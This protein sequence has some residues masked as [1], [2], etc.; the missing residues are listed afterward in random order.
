MY[1]VSAICSYIYTQGGLRFESGE[2]SVT[3]NIDGADRSLRVVRNGKGSSRLDRGEITLSDLESFVREGECIPVEID[4]EGVRVTLSLDPRSAMGREGRAAVLDLENATS[5][6]SPLERAAV[7]RSQM[8]SLPYGIKNSGEILERVSW[9]I[10]QGEIDGLSPE[11]LRNLA[12]VLDKEMTERL[13]ESQMRIITELSFGVADRTCDPY[14]LACMNPAARAV[15]EEQGFVTRSGEMPLLDVEGMDKDSLADL[16]ELGCVLDKEYGAVVGGVPLETWLSRRDALFTASGVPWS[17]RGAAVRNSSGDLI[18]YATQ[19][20]PG[21]TVTIQ[22][23]WVVDTG[24]EDL[25]ELLTHSEVVA[26]KEQVSLEDPPTEQYGAVWRS[27]GGT[28]DVYSRMPGSVLRAAVAALSDDEMSKS[29][30]WASPRD[31]DALSSFART[32]D[33]RVIISAR[34]RAEIASDKF[35]LGNALWNDPVDGGLSERLLREDERSVKAREEVSWSLGRGT[36]ELRN[37][38]HQVSRGTDATEIARLANR[39]ITSL[40]AIEE[41]LGRASE[42]VSSTSRLRGE[43][44]AEAVKSS[45]HDHALVSR[46]K[47]E[48]K[49]ASDASIVE[50]SRVVEASTAVGY[51]R[52]CLSKASEAASRRD[53]ES[54]KKM[55]F[56]AVEALTEAD[57]K[58]GK[59]TESSLEMRNILEYGLESER[60]SARRHHLRLERLS[61]AEGYIT[62]AA[63]VVGAVTNAAVSVLY[64]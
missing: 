39:G 37:L 28:I 17:L 55:I 34:S 10:S 62:T 49:A 33:H 53:A 22:P 16:R 51:A 6:L 13:V 44:L 40:R 14:L 43:W 9:A 2:C 48:M 47:T 21:S 12:S 63:T 54:V 24:R 7:A 26:D 60:A 31:F 8:E 5:T 57:H 56:A 15:L 32:E 29:L 23:V 11:A 64:N 38:L 20:E 35:T 30:A 46:V 25:V 3:L 50:S 36:A 52:S 27:Q 58:V 1:S 18:K 45:I 59:S 19:A 61:S 42:S 4:I 41:T